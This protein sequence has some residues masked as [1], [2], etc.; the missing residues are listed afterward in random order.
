MTGLSYDLATHV[1]T[2]SAEALSS[3]T[4]HAARRAL[5]DGLGVM[6]GASGSAPEVEPFV[7]EAMETPGPATIVGTGFASSPSLAAMANGAM[8]HALDF[9][10]AFDP[11]P[12]HPNAA[13][14]P[15]LLALAEVRG[16]VSGGELLSAL[17]V[18]C[19]LVCRMGLSLRQPMEVGGWYPP[20]ILGG[21]G[22]VAGAARLLRLDPRQVADAWS[23]ML[24][25]TGT[26]GE[27]KYDR[28]TV[29]RAVREAFPAQT[30]VE[31]CSL[32][33]RGVRG[34]DAPIEGTAG[35]FALYANGQFAETDLRNGLGEEFWIEQLSFKRW[36]ACRGTH[37]HIEGARAILQRGLLTP[38]DIADIVLTIGPVQRMLIEP[39][40]SKAAPATV[41]DAKFSLPFTVAAA[42]VHGDVT[43][44]SFTDRALSDPRILA[45]AARIRF[46]ERSDWGRERGAAGEVEVIMNDG[47]RHSEAVDVAMGAP[48]APMSDDDLLAK[49]VDCAGRATVPPDNPERLG[50]AILSLG[51]HDDALAIL[52]PLR[53]L[54]AS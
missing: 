35:F 8:A 27:I 14:I 11:A 54:A 34:F 53:A 44:D 46:I 25:R 37:P 36:P 31:V 47:A 4:L 51:A 1:A 3:T 33:A 21:F 23:M 22:A 19:D 45:L 2:F 38:D 30:A 28:D 32:A 52:A 7:A 40:A 17:A 41:I 10:D 24:C 13:L 12:C 49:F 42:F 6:L 50:H 29:L 18:G 9:E 5:L 16:G 20:P 26:P 43:L 48:V 39:A 15:A